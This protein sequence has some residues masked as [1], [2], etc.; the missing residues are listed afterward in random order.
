MR[1]V[2]VMGLVVLVAVGVVW[3]MG[4]NEGVGPE[5]VPVDESDPESGAVGAARRR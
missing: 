5:V 4:A 1:A 2:T 3:W